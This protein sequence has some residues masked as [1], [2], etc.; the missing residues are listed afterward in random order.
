MGDE[1]TAGLFLKR[2]EA[3]IM[4]VAALPV[5]TIR[6]L[7]HDWN[8]WSA[9]R[10]DWQHAIRSGDC[11]VAHG[12]DR[13]PEIDRGLIARLTGDWI[14]ELDV[15]W[16]GHCHAHESVF[17]QVREV[18]RAVSV[19]AKVVGIHGPEKWIVR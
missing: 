4:L 3:S 10:P 11:D 5:R 14:N 17:H 13:A 2:A 9:R 16:Q 6:I 7:A 15:Q 12:H 8:T 1:C 18:N 19:Y